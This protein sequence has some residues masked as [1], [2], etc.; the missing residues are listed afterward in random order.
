MKTYYE[1]DFYGLKRRLP[2]CPIGG[3]LKIAAFNMLGDNQLTAVV[4]EK[5]YEKI[6]GIEF[7]AIVTAECKGIAFAQ[8][9]SELLYKRRG[10]KFFVVVRKSFK[11]YMSNPVS[12]PVRSITTSKE[13]TLWLSGDEAEKLNGK[14]V[15]FADDVIS[16]GNT[17]EAVA[18][19]LKKAGAELIGELCVFAEGA[20]KNRRGLVYLKELPLFDEEGSVKTSF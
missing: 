11:L 12:V 15:I 6:A 5:A 4:A 2:L 13:Q 1:A 8:S 20:A 7:D 3:G 10:Q 9:L 14:K 19:L 17:V 18:E 16:T